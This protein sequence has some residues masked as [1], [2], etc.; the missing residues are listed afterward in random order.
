MVDGGRQLDN[1]PSGS[2][3]VTMRVGERLLLDTMT[4]PSGASNQL[5]GEMWR[6]GWRPR[7]LRVP[8]GRAA[9]VVVVAV[10]VADAGSLP[11]AGLERVR[12]RDVAAEAEGE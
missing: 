2:M 10:A 3:Q 4:A 9:F 5:C 12:R 11:A 6:S 7:S 8:I 1:G